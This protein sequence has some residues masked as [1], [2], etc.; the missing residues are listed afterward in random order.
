[1][2]TA[3]KAIVIIFYLIMCSLN[4][5]QCADWTKIDSA[6]RCLTLWCPTQVHWLGMTVSTNSES[7]SYG[8]GWG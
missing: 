1:M 3:Q 7:G 8:A 4:K 6:L 5:I 2:N